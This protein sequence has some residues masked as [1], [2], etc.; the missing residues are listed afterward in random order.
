MVATLLF[1]SAATPDAAPLNL[2]EEYRAIKVEQSR[3][4]H[5]EAFAMASLPAA[6]IED[7]QRALREQSP[8]IVHFGGH[9]GGT[10]DSTSADRGRDVVVG[11]SDGT[12]QHG[13]LMMRDDSGNLVMISE[14]VAEDLLRIHRGRIRLVV[15][16]ACHTSGLAQAISH[17]IDCVVG[18]MAAVSD[19]AAIAFSRG[20]YASVFGGT[21]VLMAFEAGQN[22]VR[23]TRTGNPDIWTLHCRDGIQSKDVYLGE[24]IGPLTLHVLLT[25]GL[26]E[27]YLEP[28]PDDVLGNL[29]RKLLSTLHDPPISWERYVTAIA[30]EYA[31]RAL[32]RFAPE[33][34]E[35]LRKALFDLLRRGTFERLIPAPT[36]LFIARDSSTYR[37]ST[38]LAT[39]LEHRNA[40]DIEGV[41]ESLT[42]AAAE[43]VRLLFENEPHLMRQ[44]LLA[45]AR[46]I[47]LLD[48]TKYNIPKR[49]FVRL[50]TSK[51]LKSLDA[52]A[53]LTLELHDGELDWLIEKMPKAIAD[54]QL[55]RLAAYYYKEFSDKTM[56]IPLFT[57]LYIEPR[58]ADEQGHLSDLLDY[59]DR[60]LEPAPRVPLILMGDPGSG[61]TS[62]CHAIVRRQLARVSHHAFSEQ[63]AFPV[64]LPL[65]LLRRDCVVLGKKLSYEVAQ[66][67]YDICVDQITQM[68]DNETG[69][70]PSRRFLFVLDGFDEL[71]LVDETVQGFLHAVGRLSQDKPLISIILTGRTFALASHFAR[72]NMN[73]GLFPKNRWKWLTIQPFTLGPNGEVERFVLSYI[74]ATKR[75][76]VS[77]DVMNLARPDA[78]FSDVAQTPVLLTMLCSFYYQIDE[79]RAS[80]DDK[81]DR[82]SVL[83]WL[84]D[85]AVRWRANPRSRA[86][87]RL[88]DDETQKRL[89][90]FQAWAWEAFRRGGTDFRVNATTAVNDT[91]L[92][93]FLV[94]P[95]EGNL[96]KAAFIHRTIAEYLAA[97]HLV[98]SVCEPLRFQSCDMLLQYCQEL[99]AENRLLDEHFKALIGQAVAVLPDPLREKLSEAATQLINLVYERPHALK[100]A[101]IRAPLLDMLAMVAELSCTMLLAVGAGEIDG[102]LFLRAAQ[103]RTA[104]TRAEQPWQLGLPIRSL[105]EVDL[106]RVQLPGLDLSRA[107]IANARFFCPSLFASSLRGAVLRNSSLRGRLPSVDLRGATFLSC[108]FI[109]INFRDSQLDD[110]VFMHCRFQESSSI[111]TS[112]ESMNG[113]RIQLSLDMANAL[114]LAD[115]WGASSQR[116]VLIDEIRWMSTDGVAWHFDPKEKT[117]VIRHVFNIATSLPDDQEHSFH[118]RINIEHSRSDRS[119]MNRM[120]TIDILYH[121]RD[122]E[123]MITIR[124]ELDSRLMHCDLQ[125]EITR[126]DNILA[127]RLGVKDEREISR[128]KALAAQLV[129]SM[130]R[131]INEEIHRRTNESLLALLNGSDRVQAPVRPKALG[132]ASDSHMGQSA[133]V[134]DL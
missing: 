130:E 77:S 5:R 73:E 64:F 107:D 56:D 93:E 42:G 43:I 114:E 71:A 18:T 69:S 63:I 27:D 70:F 104:S 102:D 61:K 79:L 53:T 7:L 120:L 35:N 134:T 26:H 96:G 98:R 131:M 121:V 52:D 132:P 78:Q 41:R 126:V 57:A 81:V 84:I 80:D 97:S 22:E 65:S 108:D 20:F 125:H 40:L 91:W 8:E 50:V 24:A 54:D 15:L 45:T 89:A 1:I 117:F 118:V 36:H 85:Q 39:L 115:A 106:S 116:R 88:S 2:D 123:P 46:F 127:R 99:A 110:T 111:S 62:A 59:V 94:R 4:R 31:P 68:L 48:T 83:I 16:N 129:S 58:V 76:E 133:R 72:M 32:Q 3:A 33:H 66:A 109:E 11:A 49:I 101:E 82:I 87:E 86:R 10:T 28:P 105:S 47:A 124:T 92:V 12:R 21:N 30:L 95:V 37:I 51:Q 29:A 119:L 122:K 19:S 100:W 60:W 128:R 75:D 113:R 25:L 34:A 17:H 55:G 67:L 9:G 44:Q 13:E 38:F 103:L 23:L 74:V 14:K 90:T 6:R 112:F